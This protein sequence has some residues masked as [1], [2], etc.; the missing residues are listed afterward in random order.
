MLRIPTSADTPPPLL[1]PRV[2]DIHQVLDAEGEAKKS[3]KRRRKKGGGEH[4]WENAP[5]PGRVKRGDK[6]K[7]RLALAGVGF[8]FLAIV[9]GLVA[10]M[11]GGKRPATEAADGKP[12]LTAQ[13]P[14]PKPDEP[15]AVAPRSEVLV[16]G[17]AEPLARTFLMATTV[18]EILPL[19]RDRAVAEARIR[20]FHAGGKIEAPGLSQ[21]NAGQGMVAKGKLYSVPVL[22]R[23]QESKSLAFVD[24][25]EGLKIDWESWVGWSEITWKEFRSTKPVTS[26]VF[27]VILSPVDYYNFDFTDDGKWKSYRLESP[28]KEHAI[29]GYV[30]KGSLLD[31]RIHL[32]GDQKNV[33]MMLSLKFPA[34]AKSD[35]QVEIERLICEGWVEGGDAP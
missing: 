29:Y 11:V 22:T 26:H 34:N 9:A 16:L 8:A 30:E 19:V 32:D 21:F 12:G 5:K 2:K 3:N 1:A 7:T 4:S 13:A 14:P 31:R 15:P 6:R 18:D 17:E 33:L 10:T 35:S 24:T 25:P 20:K 23:D 27:R 28:D